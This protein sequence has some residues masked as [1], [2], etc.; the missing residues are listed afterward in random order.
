VQGNAT[1]IPAG[2]DWSVFTSV[3]AGQGAILPATGV[4]VGEEYM[5]SNHGANALLI[6]PPVGGT[7][8]GGALNAAY[9]LAAGK[10]GRF[11]NVAL[12]SWTANP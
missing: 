5:V 4:S 8:G 12:L 11:R 1:A 2:Q 6:Y 9:S 10:T 3:S 7:V